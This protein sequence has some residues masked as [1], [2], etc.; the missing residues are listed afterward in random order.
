MPRVL[1]LFVL[2]TGAGCSPGVPEQEPPQVGDRA[3]SALQTSPKHDL[4]TPAASRT[5]RERAGSDTAPRPREE[6]PRRILIH[7]RV[8]DA[9]GALVDRGAVRLVI[10]G[11]PGLRV[12]IQP[13]GTFSMRTWSKGA[14]ALVA[15]CHDQGAGWLSGL[16]LSG[17]DV[18]DL[19]IVL[20]RGHEIAGTLVDP[21]GTTIAGWKVEVSMPGI[22]WF[23]EI[24][25]DDEGLTRDRTVTD[26]RGRFRLR[27]LRSGSFL[28]GPFRDQGHEIDTA[29]QR[30]VP[31]GKLDV[32]LVME[33]HRIHARV[34]DEDGE[35]VPE[36]TLICRCVDERRELKHEGRGEAF[37]PVVA[38]HSYVVR[39]F[40][41]DRAVF[42]QRIDVEQRLYVHEVQFVAPRQEWGRLRV[43]VSGPTGDPWE[44]RVVATLRSEKS[45][46]PI[47][48]E[49]LRLRGDAAGAVWRKD[50][51]PGTY[52]L[53]I[54]SQVLAQVAYTVCGG[55]LPEDPPPHAF[56]QR[57]VDV[58]P[59][60]EAS[61][62]ICLERGACLRLELP[63]LDD[64]PPE[65]RHSRAQRAARRVWNRDAPAVRVLVE[66]LEHGVRRHL[67]FRDPEH[68]SFGFDRVPPGFSW[69]SWQRLLPGTWTVLLESEHF[70]PVR[71][72]VVVVRGHESVD[73]K[74]ELVPLRR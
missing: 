11:L 25:G 27:G 67:A 16:E 2:V 71:R 41:P 22:A 42:E 55:P 18:R 48:S 69:S 26:E 6:Q 19:R 28:V 33:Q 46:F 49:T 43:R 38:G 72:E 58:H 54:R 4:V 61:V 15:L 23:V 70:E 34:V 32:V 12:E 68:G 63:P 21:H 30:S 59:L 8:F 7:G 74:A 5:E 39:Y 17:E 3:G 53:D 20:A 1:G 52:R 13:D 73:V 62:D 36:G 37:F 40:A 29:A 65:D 10:D 57:T 35:V 51:P 64:G 24:A 31:A 66:S 44:G 56:V 50:L 14:T 9:D 60:E 45:S 47:T